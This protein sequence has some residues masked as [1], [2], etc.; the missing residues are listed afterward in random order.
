MVRR[1]LPAST[2]TSQEEAPVQGIPRF[3][4][5]VVLLAA[6]ALVVVAC[7]GDDDDDVATASED[8]QA[9]IIAY[10]DARTAGDIDALIALYDENAVIIGQTRMMAWRMS[11][12]YAH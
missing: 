12:K 8:P 3:L 1:F 11:L 6:L 5:M 2:P 7:G 10:Q 4:V 9:V